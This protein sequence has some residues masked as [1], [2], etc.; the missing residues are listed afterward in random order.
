MGSLCPQGVQ[1][2]FHRAMKSSV[3]RFC[4]LVVPVLTG[5]ATLSGCASLSETARQKDDPAPYFL[6]QR[7]RACVEKVGVNGRFSI[8]YKTRGAEEALHGGFEWEQDKGLIAITLL[9]PLGQEVAKID[10]MPQL[11]TFTIP[12]KPPK[13]AANA[14]KLIESQLGWT[15]PVSWLKDW[16]QG[17]AVD[18]EGKP[19][20][21]SPERK[22][23][24]TK[25]K[26]Q[27]NYVSW[28]DGPVMPLPKRINLVKGKDAT[29]LDVNMKLVID[30]W[31][32]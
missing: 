12:G 19:F 24:I 20:I 2:L 14:E 6:E 22:E 17:C 29:D 1:Q 13:S 10:V 32:F 18:A 26:W 7:P 27:I 11:T 8:Y 3:F 25:D 9:S 16:L 23:V 31:R 30:G 15:L 28:I 21:A 5:A 4:R